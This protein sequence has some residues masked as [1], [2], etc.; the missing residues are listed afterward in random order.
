MCHYYVNSLELYLLGKKLTEIGK[1]SMP[2]TG[3]KNIHPN[4]DTCVYRRIRPSI[5]HHKRDNHPI[6]LAD[7]SS[8]YGDSQVSQIRCRRN[9]KGS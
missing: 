9:A 5:L 6:G 3:L 2:Q 4:Y 8:L 1:D 7:P